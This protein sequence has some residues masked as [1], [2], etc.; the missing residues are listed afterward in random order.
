MKKPQ[1]QRAARRATSPARR[2]TS[3]ANRASRRATDIACMWGA[4][5]DKGT[6][7]NTNQDA[8]IG[9][10]LLFAVAD[11][12]GGYEGGQIASR[13]AVNV[14]LRETFQASLPAN[15]PQP[16][17]HADQHNQFSPAT[18]R[19][20]QAFQQ[21][22]R[23]VI[24][25][26]QSDLSLAAM[27]T[28]LCAMQ[29][30]SEAGGGAKYFSLANVGDSRIYLLSGQKLRQI[31]IDHTYVNDLVRG[32]LITQEEAAVHKQRHELTRVLGNFFPIDT[33]KVDLW[34]VAAQPGDRYMLC[35]DGLALHV[36]DRLIFRLLSKYSNPQEAA[37]MLLRAALDAGGRDN[38]TV[39]VIDVVETEQAADSP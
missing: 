38:I 30:H 10:G 11:G 36:P 21:A 19:L 28:T 15:W 35:T 33:L 26:S 3:R 29:L 16:H 24:T 13:L 14:L 4:V 2:A 12:L 9:N 31:T 23:E 17:D 7:R 20:H 18:R 27:S 32:G 34:E 37:N 25:K 22:N 39:L 1:R 5:S 6:E 8:Y